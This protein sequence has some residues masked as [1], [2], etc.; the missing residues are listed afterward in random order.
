[1]EDASNQLEGEFPGMNLGREVDPPR[2]WFLAPMEVNPAELPGITKDEGLLV[3]SQNEGIVLAGRVF[4]LLSM[5]PT[6]HSQV[7]TEPPV[8]REAEEHL[9]PVGFGFQQIASPQA[10]LEEAGVKIPKDP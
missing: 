4:G 10:A 1:M 6:R 3:L 2:R 5:E 7:K 9:F 8:S